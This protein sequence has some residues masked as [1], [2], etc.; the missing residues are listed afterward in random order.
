M[1]D[2]YT[3]TYVC[4]FPEAVCSSDWATRP[5]QRA[6]NWLTTAISEREEVRNKM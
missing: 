6:Q 5:H 2:T 4:V 1:S 3:Y